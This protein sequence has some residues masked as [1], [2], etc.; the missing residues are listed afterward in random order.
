MSRFS[1]TARNKRGEAVTGT[2]EA[3]S[4]DRVAEQ[5]FNSS[6]TPINID[7]AEEKKAEYQALSKLFK[8]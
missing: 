3:D 4:P 6:L 2:I 7:E 1:Y 5:L 8:P